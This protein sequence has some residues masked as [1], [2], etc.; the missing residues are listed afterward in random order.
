MAPLVVVDGFVVDGF[1]VDG[2]VD[3]CSCQ[4]QEHQQVDYLLRKNQ[5]EMLELK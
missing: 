5:V 3:G 4:Y 2:F 1:V